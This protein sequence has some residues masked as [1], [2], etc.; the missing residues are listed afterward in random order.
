M[1]RE[2][3]CIPLVSKNQSPEKKK[4]FQESTRD[5][6]ENKETAN[7]KETVNWDRVKMRQ[8]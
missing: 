2:K 8:P 1:D 5:Q 4:L 6:K 3:N 7:F